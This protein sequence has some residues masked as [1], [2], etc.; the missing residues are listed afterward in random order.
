MVERSRNDTPELCRVGRGSPGPVLGTAPCAHLHLHTQP[1]G[2]PGEPVD[3]V[4]PQPEVP[5][6]AAKALL[7]LLPVPVEGDEATLPSLNDGPA[8]A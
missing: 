5:T 1:G 2:P 4:I 6:D 8:A 7:V 3:V